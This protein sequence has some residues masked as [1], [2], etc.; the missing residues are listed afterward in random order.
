VCILL[1]CLDSI[2]L[3][4]YRRHRT[5]PRTRRNRTVQRNKG[6]KRQ[7][8]GIVDAYISWSNAIGV[9]GLDASPP[10]VEP[11]F[12]Q[13]TYK[14][15]VMDVFGNYFFV[16]PFHVSPGILA[17]FPSD[18]EL[19]VGDQGIPAS[20]VRQGL[21]PCAPF[22]PSLA[23]ST[24]L[25]V[26]YRNTHLRCPH[27]AIQ[28]FVKGLCDLHGI[29]FRPYLSQQFSI[30]YDLYLS[31]REDVQQRVAVALGRDSPNWRLSPACPACTYKLEGEADLIFKMLV[32]M[33]GND[34][35]KRIICRQ[36]LATPAEGE[37]EPEGPQV[38]DS[39]ELTDLRTVGGD[40]LLSREKVDRWAR[41][42]L[43]EMLPMPESVSFFC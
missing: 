31:I 37:P 4:L 26:L 27:L 24:R 32:T 35:L 16:Y 41:A 21:M 25:L 2:I 28:P 15:Q 14:I 19:A 34:S 20:L 39:R 13:G 42:I 18:A 5:D 23:I 11:E 38:G 30:C 9:E 1:R 12:L 10:S 33:D 40:Y 22:S 7:F 17:T 29:P 3:F 36:P 43:Q 6:F 8:E